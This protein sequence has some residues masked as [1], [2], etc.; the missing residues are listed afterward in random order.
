MTV[1]LAAGVVHHISTLVTAF[2]GFVGTRVGGILYLVGGLVLGTVAGHPE[3]DK[4]FN[5]YL[6]K[7]F[8]VKKRKKILKNKQKGKK[9]TCHSLP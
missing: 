4:N 5:L 6:K 1:N 8:L 3:M 9:L 7:L 2:S